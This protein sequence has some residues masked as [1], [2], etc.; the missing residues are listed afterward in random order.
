L[1]ATFWKI[2]YILTN[3]Y[4]NMGGKIKNL[5][6]AAIAWFM[7]MAML[8]VGTWYDHFFSEGNMGGIF[9]TIFFISFIVYWIAYLTFRKIICRALQTLRFGAIAL[10]QQQVRGSL[11]SHKPSRFRVPTKSYLQFWFKRMVKKLWNYY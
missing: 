5:K 7:A 11:C 1:T 4:Y 2:I 8:F 3:F 6:S 10:R 9:G